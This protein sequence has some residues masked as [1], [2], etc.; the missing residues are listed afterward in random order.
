[1]FFSNKTSCLS[2]YTEISRQANARALITGAAIVVAR[3]V[4][5]A[6]IVSLRQKPV[7]SFPWFRYRQF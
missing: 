7:M 3:T 1:M 2:E 6:L 5:A 4:L